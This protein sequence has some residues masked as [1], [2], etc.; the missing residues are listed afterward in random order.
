MTFTFLLRMKCQIKLLN[1]FHS[2]LLNLVQQRYVVVVMMFLSMTF[3]F[4]LRM[5]F[6]IVLTQMVYVPNVN[7]SSMSHTISNSDMICPVKNHIVN[8]ITEVDQR[9]SLSVN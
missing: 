5:N 2:G 6:P 9:A 3:T 4:F 7:Q 1:N 8:N